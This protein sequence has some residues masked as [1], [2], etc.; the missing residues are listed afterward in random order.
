MRTQFPFYKSFDDVYQDLSINQKIEFIDNILDVQFLRK[1]IDD[2]KFK[3]SILKHI[4][5]AQKHSLDKSIKGYLDSQKS[6]KIPNP[7]FGCYD[8]SS[9]LINT[10]GGGSEIP[11]EEEQGEEQGEDKEQGELFNAS[12]R[13]ASISISSKKDTNNHK[14]YQTIREVDKFLLDD[15][16]SDEDIIIIS[17]FI[18]YRDE[19]Y[20]RTKDKKYGLKTYRAIQLFMSE[21]Y[22]S[23]DI[24]KAFETMELNEWTTYKKEWDKNK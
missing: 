7:F 10:Q 4:W 13:S 24:Y 12:L 18:Q 16:V 8:D 22:K 19:M 23:N 20:N 11:K 6:K 14:P 3:D 17:N 15:D 2:V 9:I 5:N 1:K 21:I